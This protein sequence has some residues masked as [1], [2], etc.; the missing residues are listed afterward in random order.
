[1]WKV[2]TESIN[3]SILILLSEYLLS[4]DPFGPKFPGVVVNVL[5][6][7]PS[8]IIPDNSQEVRDFFDLVQVHPLAFAHKLYWKSWMVPLRRSSECLLPSRRP[9][10]LTDFWRLLFP[11]VGIMSLYVMKLDAWS[12]RM[13]IRMGKSTGQS[14]RREEK[15]KHGRYNSS[16]GSSPC[17]NSLSCTESSLLPSIKSAILLVASS[18]FWGGKSSIMAYSDSDSKIYDTPRL[19]GS[20][21]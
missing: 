7:F 20:L 15:R 6:F 3:K 10:V 8:W 14:K 2:T 21:D 13:G 1:M 12:V 16:H 18:T 9:W 11:F 4:R 17:W 5:K 19:I